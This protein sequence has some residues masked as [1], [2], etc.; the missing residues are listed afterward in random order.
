[1]KVIVFGGAGFLGSHVA[2]ALSERGHE[3]TVFDLKKSPYLRDGQ[4]SIVGDINNAELVMSAVKNCDVVYTFAGIA[5]LT[6]AKENPLE[7]VRN[8]IL[9]TTVLLEAARKNKVKRFVLAS[10]LYVYS[11]SG[12]F[13]RS[14]K[15]ACE[16]LIDNY[17]EVYG[18]DYTII[19][20]GSLYGP[21]AGETNW[22]QKVL[23]QAL[24]EKKIIRN[25]DGEELRD[26]IHVNDAA[27]LSVEI[28]DEAYR[29]QHVIVTGN[30]Q[31]KVKDLMVMIKEML[32]NEIKLEFKAVDSS[33]HYEITP[34]TFNP[35]LA[36]RIQASDY[37]DL[38]QGIL[39]LIGRIYQDHLPH[40]KHNGIYVKD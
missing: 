20:Y 6:E 5:D 23:K 12:S 33:E 15:Q 10:T 38:G 13:Y 22:V 1:M 37:V 29:N 4:T 24:S 2:D 16:L 19:R 7:T 14:S 34:Y 36:K 11:K 3:V 8:N 25:G 26:Y 17:Q 32:N 18:L 35:K 9:G 40:K 30:Q 31:I 28:L 21:R 27:R 39:D